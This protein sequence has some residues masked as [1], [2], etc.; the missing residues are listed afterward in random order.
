MVSYAIAAQANATLLAAE[1]GAPVF[2]K[3]AD[4]LHDR[5]GIGAGSAGRTPDDAP[6]ATERAYE[7]RMVRAS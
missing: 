6:H 5:L 3:M 2:M 1:A 4:E 7:T